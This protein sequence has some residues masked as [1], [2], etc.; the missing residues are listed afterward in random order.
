[1]EIARRFALAR[2]SLMIRLWLCRPAA[3]RRRLAA[4]AVCLS[5]FASAESQTAFQKQEQALRDIETLVADYLA[6]S[7]PV[8]PEQR[9]KCRGIGQFEPLKGHWV[10]DPDHNYQGMTD[11][12]N[13]P[14]FV[15]DFDCRSSDIDPKYHVL[16]QKEFRKVFQ[17]HNCDLHAMNGTHFAQCLKGQRIVI[18]G[19]STMRQVFQSLACILH[20][21][22]EDGYLVPWEDATAN[23]TSVPAEK[24][25]MARDSEQPIMKQ[26]IGMFKL[27]NGAEVHLVSFGIFNLELWDDAMAK[28]L[29][30]TKKDVL[31][32]EFGAWYPRF[33]NWD[34][35]RPWERYQK[36]VY[37]LLDQRLRQMTTNILWRSYGPTHFGGPTGTFTGIAFDLPEMPKPDSCEPA[38]YGEYYYDTEVM[39]YLKTKCMDGHCAHIHILPVY[40]LSLLAHSSHHGSFGRGTDDR[41][42][43]CRRYCA[44]VIDTWNQVLY[45]K[46]CFQPF[47][48][49]KEARAP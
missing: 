4:L 13:C 27:R 41:S 25:Y 14:A 29:P 42:I 10:K 26:N 5:L 7:E 17:P 28:F 18:V 43:D 33:A 46:L 31:Y 48:K 47:G 8:P 45:N 37:E 21:D 3:C 38:R 23:H 30:M 15:N 32:V 6:P 22:V 2:D 44:N 35:Y 16:Q 11:P 1:M 34:M 20:E 40:H 24:Q 9:R 36:D 49:G 12:K 19:D 39:R